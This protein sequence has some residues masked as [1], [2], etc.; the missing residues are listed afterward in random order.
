MEL[1]KKRQGFQKCKSICLFS[2]EKARQRTQL[3]Y[4]FFYT[5]FSFD[6]FFMRFFASILFFSDLITSFQPVLMLIIKNTSLLS[7]NHVFREIHD[8]DLRT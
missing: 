8:Q 7:E 1:T 4:S 6:L 2:S 5:A 3:L